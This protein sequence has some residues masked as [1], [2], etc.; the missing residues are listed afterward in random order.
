MANKTLLGYVQDFCRKQGISPPSTVINSTDET[1]L[2]IWGLLYEELQELANRGEW[3]EL[4]RRAENW[5]HANAADYGALSLDDDTTPYINSIVPDTLICSN[6]RIPVAGPVSPA[7]WAQMIAFAIRPTTYSF[8]IYNGY[9]RIYPV[10][11]DLVNTLFS[12]E[13][14]TNAT[15]LAF[16]GTT[17]KT[18]FT[19]DDDGV[20]LPTRIVE[21]GLRWRWKKEK[22]LPYAE[23]KVAYESMVADQLGVADG[24][25]RIDMGGDYSYDKGARPKIIIPSGSWNV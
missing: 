5:P 21:A 25:S 19:A 12:L 10:P 20:L 6:L 4:K 2:Q 23:E 13:Y 16:D 1:I 3:P 14:I 15:V 11:T 9:L 22:G 24:Q 7:Q 17:E 8:R 18:E